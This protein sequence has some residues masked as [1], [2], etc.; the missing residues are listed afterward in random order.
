MF[1]LIKL[2]IK[3]F[4]LWGE[5]KGVAISYLCLFGIMLGCVLSST[6]DKDFET[7]TSIFGTM[8]FTFETLRVISE[9]TFL[10]YSSVIL[11]KL[12]IGEYKNKT[13][14]NMFMYPINRKKLIIAKLIIVWIFT[15][16][17][18]ILANLIIGGALIVINNNFWG[19][20]MDKVTIS[21]MLNIAGKDI[22]ITFCSSFISFVPLLFGMMK[23]S[24]PACIVSSII[25][26]MF[27]CSSGSY[28]DKIPYVFII[29]KN[30]VFGL[31][32]IFIL[33]ISIM[34]IEK[35]D[36]EN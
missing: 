31:I 23:K 33:C 30:L 36:L 10:I 16:V 18:I 9:A 15:F 7:M 35:Y 19:I 24:I 3:K 29:L 25:V 4:K 1:K 13:I 6:Y 5:I 26:V 14:M 11:S 32:G 21:S 28:G 20:W 22:A 34:N 2:E 8:A 12:I 17:S 27:V